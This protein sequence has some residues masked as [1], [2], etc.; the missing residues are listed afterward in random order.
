MHDVKGCSLIDKINGGACDTFQDTYI[1]IYKWNKNDSVSHCHFK[2][3]NHVLIFKSRFNIDV[4]FI[5]FRNIASLKINV[6]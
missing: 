4:F 3:N 5:Y 1:Y 6:T 2:K